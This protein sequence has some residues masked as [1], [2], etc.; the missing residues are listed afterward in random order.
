MNTSIFTTNRPKSI[1]ERIDDYIKAIKKD[2]SY[3]VTFGSCMRAGWVPLQKRFV[4]LEAESINE[5]HRLAHQEFGSAYAFI[6]PI[7]E[8][9]EQISRFGLTPINLSTIHNHGGVT[10]S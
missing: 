10:L 7:D 6:Y 5:A 2:R 3:F 1:Q 4:T 9:D 8:L